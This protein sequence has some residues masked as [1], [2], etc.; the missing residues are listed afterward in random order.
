[1]SYTYTASKDYISVFSF[2]MTTWTIN[3]DVVM[4]VSQSKVSKLNMVPELPN[5]SEQSLSHEAKKPSKDS[6]SAFTAKF[7]DEEREVISK[8]D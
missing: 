7:G 8:R 4:I 3:T 6:S 2:D 1:M 5:E